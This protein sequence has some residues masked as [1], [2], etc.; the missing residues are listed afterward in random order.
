M[1]YIA[2]KL[3]W[4]RHAVVE[5]IIGNKK[6]SAKAEVDDV[7]QRRQRKTEPSRPHAT[8]SDNLAKYQH[9]FPEICARTDGQTDRQT[10]TLTIT[11]PLCPTAE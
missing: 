11:K 4:Y 3:L 1:Y 10:N 2:A 5:A 9:V 6:L 7:S 8:Y